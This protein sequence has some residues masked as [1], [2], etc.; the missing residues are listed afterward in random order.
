LIGASHECGVA[1]AH[2]IG[3][4]VPALRFASAGTTL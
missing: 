3:L 4:R 2:S 1:T